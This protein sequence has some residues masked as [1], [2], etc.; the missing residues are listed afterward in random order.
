MFS[1]QATPTKHFI[2]DAPERRGKL[3]RI[4]GARQKSPAQSDTEAE[5]SVGN[6]LGEN[7]YRLERDLL[8]AR[9]ENRR[10]SRPIRRRGCY[11]IGKG[12][13]RKCRRSSVQSRGVRGERERERESEREKNSDHCL[14]T[15]D[16]AR[17]GDWK[18]G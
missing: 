14:V 16:K 8:A 17:R 11:V 1:S 13:R 2:I 4:D 7:R 3:Q 9:K 18:P 12:R 15:S 6:E 10:G 5:E